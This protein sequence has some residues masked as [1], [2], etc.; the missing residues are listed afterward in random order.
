[1]S[2][3]LEPPNE[4]DPE[5]D[6]VAR[7]LDEAAAEE[8]RDMRA[9]E[10]LEHAPGLDK[11]EPVLQSAWGE[12]SPRWRRRTWL[13]LMSAV[14]VAAAL[15]AIFW[16]RGAESTTGETPRDH[17]L[18]GDERGIV[19]PPARAARWDHIEW[20]GPPDGTY[21]LKVLSEN[22]DLV[23]GPI[24]NIRG[25]VHDLPP[26]VTARWPTTITIEVSTRRKDGTWVPVGSRECRLQP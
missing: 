14:G 22:G 24:D 21:R 23:Y 15:V 6:D 13:G 1:V 5:L 9:A 2:D 16:L 17:F 20:R 12:E 11:V 4:R 3:P 26:E 25:T 18:N 7:L 10:E 8:A 19:Y